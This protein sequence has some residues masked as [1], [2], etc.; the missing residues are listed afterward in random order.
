MYKI[1]GYLM[2]YP[3]CVTCSATAEA[4]I[5]ISNPCSDITLTHDAPQ[6][7]SAQY[8]QDGTWAFPSIQTLPMNMC[9]EQAVY[10]CEYISGP[11]TADIDL[12][13]FHIGNSY[14]IFDPFT[15][16][17][18]FHFDPADLATF[19]PGEYVFDITAS[20]GGETVTVPASVTIESPCTPNS[21]E[22]LNDPF[23]AA[24]P[25]YYKISTPAL[26][27]P[28]DLAT[29]GYVHCGV[30][31]IEFIP[32]LN[33]NIAIFDF[34]Y[35]NQVLRI[36]PTDDLSLVGTWE[37]KFKYYYEHDPVNFAVMSDVFNIVIS[38]GECVEGMFSLTAPTMQHLNYFVGDDELV[39]TLPLWHSEPWFCSDQ[40]N[41]DPTLNAGDLDMAV[42]IEDGKLIVYTTELTMAGTDVAG[43]TYSVGL[44]ATLRG[45]TSLA[46]IQITMK[47]PCKHETHIKLDQ[48]VLPH[49][50]Y[51]LFE[52]MSHVLIADPVTTLAPAGMMAACG[53]VTYTLVPPANMPANFMSY[54][55]PSRT[56]TLY[57]EDMSLINSGLLIYSITATLDNWPQNLGGTATSAGDIT[58]NDP[59]LNP[60]TLIPGQQTNSDGDYEEAA[61]FTFPTVNVEPEICLTEAKFECQYV[62]GPYLGD[63]DLCSFAWESSYA[64]FNSDTG[65]HTLVTD[66][67]DTFPEGVYLFEVTITIGEKTEMVPFSMVM[68]E[69]C[70][71]QDFVVI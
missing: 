19:P 48:A 39:Y 6:G 68:H 44:S 71:V 38:D 31:A 62:G 23:K 63:L 51:T 7:A 4:A 2:D 37:M 34:D 12:C 29:I 25:F 16:E 32:Q 52:S 64:E 27:I 8:D 46:T 10:T 21:I 11:V 26:S 5:T 22:I 65:E 45:V 60:K 50:S 14:G 17:F 18:D 69:P 47:N 58:I 56:L 13:D 70:D 35:E 33:I 24:A 61:T 3:D 15:G 59:C 28:F 40:V 55:A 54:D 66:D 41:V 9:V 57:S 67:M 36:G 42:R 49:L 43:H 30:P 20:V 53:P 1:T